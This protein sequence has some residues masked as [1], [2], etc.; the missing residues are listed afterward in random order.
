MRPL[1]KKTEREIE[2]YLTS[3]QGRR[4]LSEL[5]GKIIPLQLV[6]EASEGRAYGEEEDRRSKI[7]NEIISKNL[8]KIPFVNM[9]AIGKEGV[10]LAHGIPYRVDSRD[11]ARANYNN[12]EYSR[13]M[14]SISYKQGKETAGSII[15]GEILK[16][17]PALST[18]GVSSATSEGKFFQPFGI[19]LG[20]DTGRIYDAENDDLT[21]VPGGIKSEIRIPLRDSNRGAK[22]LEERVAEAARFA[23]RKPS[24]R[25]GDQDE[26]LVGGNYKIEGIY[27]LPN[28]LS[29]AENKNEILEISKKYNL[30][31]YT[32]EEGRG[33]VQ[34]EEPKI[35]KTNATT[36]R[37]TKKAA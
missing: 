11:L 1:G 14:N 34:Y 6:K 7:R 36:K 30:P 12:P 31:L 15:L 37:K 5:N 4:T 22:P 13:T 23:A 20:K 27:A 3:P 28:F 17:N 33:F 32:F 26:F 16:N 24:G 18:I 9:Q 29:Y 25:Q 21:S 19:I 35:K 2:E 8:D 10:Q